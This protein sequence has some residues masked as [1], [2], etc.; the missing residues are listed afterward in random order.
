MVDKFRKQTSLRRK[1]GHVGVQICITFFVEVVYLKSGFVLAG[2]ETIYEIK[3]LTLVMY[4]ICTVNY[5]DD[6]GG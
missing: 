6:T 4:L 3:L 2:P 1:R 5:Y